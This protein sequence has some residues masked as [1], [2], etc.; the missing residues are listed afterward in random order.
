MG[1]LVNGGIFFYY[2]I[3]RIQFILRSCQERCWCKLT[4]CLQQKITYNRTGQK[5][6]LPKKLGVR[7]CARNSSFILLHLLI[8]GNCMKHI[9][10]NSQILKAT[11]HQNITVRIDKTTCLKQI[12]QK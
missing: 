4:I 2:A 1:K 5:H 3:H 11:E 9:M 10:R 7:P 8:A 6:E 12:I